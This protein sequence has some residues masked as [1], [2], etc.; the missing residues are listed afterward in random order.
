MTEIK[1]REI[2]Q[3]E[4]TIQ[5]EQH[6]EEIE[7]EQ[8]DVEKLYEFKDFQQTSQRIKRNLIITCIVLVGFILTMKIM[9]N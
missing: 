6:G 9:F 7:I 8:H 3:D 4:E 1:Q 5:T 2:E